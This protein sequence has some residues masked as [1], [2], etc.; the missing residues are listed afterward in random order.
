MRSD[1][2]QNR[3]KVL[4]AAQRLIAESGVGVSTEEIAKAA[5][6]GIG[7]V[8]RH[9][10]TKEALVSEVFKASMATFVEEGRAL[11]DLPDPREALFTLLRRSAK[12]SSAKHAHAGALAA[13]GISVD[14]AV[15]EGRAELPELLATLL[16]RA[17]A[18]GTVRPDVG[19]QELAALMIAA[20][21]AAKHS[22]RA[23]DLILDGL[24]AGQ[25]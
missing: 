1:A 17:Q 19:V 23:V 16:A 8:F 3:A 9:F 13:A 21:H 2:A 10:P 15:A 18:A 12:L 20:G 11:L 7:T 14:E 25:F 24:K 4:A 22:P 5:G 6:V